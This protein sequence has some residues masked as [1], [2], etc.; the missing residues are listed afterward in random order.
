MHS[1][2]PFIIHQFL[3]HFYWNFITACDDIPKLKDVNQ[4]RSQENLFVEN[5]PDTADSFRRLFKQAISI[6]FFR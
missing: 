1:Q 5:Y 3:L 6:L 2:F 4:F